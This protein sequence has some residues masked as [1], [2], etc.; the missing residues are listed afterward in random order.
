ALYT[1]EVAKQMKESK[2]GS[3]LKHFPGYGNNKD[4]HKS[5]AYDERDMETFETEDFLPFISAI[6]VGADAVLV[7]HNVVNC[8][9]SQLPASLSP[10]VHD[11][12]RTKLNF[13]GVIMTD[14]TSMA[15]IK[16]FTDV[17]TAVQAV[18]AGNDIIIT[19]NL[20]TEYNAVL[21]AIKTG[22]ISTERINQAVTRILV[23]K[24]EL[25]LIEK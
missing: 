25:E 13:N 7:S 11:I 20:H 15:G 22:E 23:W 10:A 8:M 2:I 24:M 18:V 1:A 21:D 3:V 4:T 6:N 17:N 9:D 12:L 5:V 16:P 14:D 19:S